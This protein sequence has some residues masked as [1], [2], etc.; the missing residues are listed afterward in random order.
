VLGDEEEVLNIFRKT[1]KRKLFHSCLVFVVEEQ[2]GM[3]YF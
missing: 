3:E 1:T 2:Q